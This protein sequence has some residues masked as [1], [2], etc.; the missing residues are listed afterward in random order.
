MLRLKLIKAGAVV[1]RNTRRIRFLLA[2]GFQS[3]KHFLTLELDN[4]FCTPMVFPVMNSRASMALKSIEQR[5]T[6]T[7]LLPA[8]L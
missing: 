5:V 2:R 6:Q 7:A 8:L 4:D 3:Q 1:M